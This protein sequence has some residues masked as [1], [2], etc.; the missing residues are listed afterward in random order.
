MKRKK[1]NNI[2]TKKGNYYFRIR[3]YNEYGRQLECTISLNTK[4]KSIAK[5]RG[6]IVAMEVEDIKDG[7]LQRFQFK[8]YFAFKNDKGA[9]ILIDKSLQDTINDYLEYRKCMVKPKTYK[10]DKSALNQL[11]EFVGYTK[12]VEEL[13]YRDFEG[14]NGLIQHLRNRG[15]GDVGINTSLA[16]LKVYLNWLYE[17]EKIIPEPIKFNLLPKGVQLYH[18]FNESETNQI[19]HYID[20]NMDSFFTRCFHFYN[21]T[22][23]RPTEPFIG[24]LVG[25]YYIINGDDRKNGIPMQMQLNDEL[26][27]ILLEMQSFR[28]SKLHCKDANERVCDIFSRTLGKIVRALEF[29]GKKLTLYS[30]RH[31]YAIRRITITNGNVFDVM[32]EMGHTNTQTT[33]GYLRFPLERRL[34]DFPS[35]REYIEQHQNMPENTIRATDLRATIYSNLSKLS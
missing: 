30:F 2:I 6:M 35:L 16:H 29:T 31:S 21:Q 32:K 23:M 5:K 19:F 8:D 15:C 24:E 12:A 18:Y 34:D 13:S 9:S 28:D 20:E 14:A 22:G 4:N 10:R 33:M 1:R 25:N 7:T 27:S 11:M 3:W 17:K 26:K